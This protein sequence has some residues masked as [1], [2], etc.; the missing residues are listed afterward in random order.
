MQANKIEMSKPRI[1]VSRCL[2]FAHCRYNGDVIRDDF[3]ENLTPFVEYITVCPEVEIGLGIPRKPI[4]LIKEND[5]LELY[6]P[7]TEKLFT[8][9][10]QD[11]NERVLGSLE[12]IDGFILKGR[13]PSCG[14]KDVKVY[15][16]RGK[17][18]VLGKDAGIFGGAVLEKF[19]HLPVEEEGRLTNL[20]IREHF[21][22][23]LYTMKRFKR[24]EKE[25][26]MKDLVKF[27]ADNKYLF[28]AYDQNQSRKLGQIVANHDKLTLEEVVQTYK[29]VLSE[30]LEEAPK[31]SNY[32]NSLM[33]IFGYFS[34]DLSPEERQF[35][36]E[37]F[38]KFR[39]DKIH[40][41]VPVNLLKSYVLR[42]KDK[43][44]VDQTIWEPF[45][46]ELLD[47]SDTGK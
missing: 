7:D 1:V 12:D 4:R 47:I 44:L 32:I 24:I 16:G 17:A 37:S 13:S 11:Y 30:T 9:E 41:S 23:K 20:K 29:L 5:Q 43:N 34:Q 45:P 40:L 25:G 31:H 22:T 2:G 8:K 36:L 27:H 6:Q 28:I 39:E 19:P 38:D 3:V 18:P 15:N 10:M 33:H 14:I 46:D 26:L 35:I 21:L 42:F